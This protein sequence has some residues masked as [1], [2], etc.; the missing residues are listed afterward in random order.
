MSSSQG[1]LRKRLPELALEALMIVFA[2]LVALGF[3]EWRDEQQMREFADRAKAAVLAEIR[4]NLDEFQTTRPAMASNIAMLEEVVSERD[5]ALLD[6]IGFTLPDISSAAW[7]AALVSQAAGYLDYDWVIE[8]SKLYDIVD[9]YSHIADGVID[10]ISAVLGLPPTLEQVNTI[11]GRQ[12]I[13]VGVHEEME[14]RLA[15]LLE[16]LPEDED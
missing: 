3:E 8:V 7:N 14:E 11:Y 9:T 15:A 12:L 10:A 4:A 1:S 5:L 6:N 2:V 13:L 16:P